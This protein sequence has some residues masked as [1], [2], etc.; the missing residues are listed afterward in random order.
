MQAGYTINLKKSDLILV[1]DLVFIGGRFRIDLAQMFLP[2][3]R[4][5]A[6]IS[7]VWSFCQDALIS[8]VRSFCQAG[9]YNPAHQF[10]RLLGLMV[11]TLL[12]IPY[13]HLHMR[14][15][16]WHLK[17]RWLS[18]FGL[19]HWMFMNANLV[20]D[21]QWWM[22]ESNLLERRPFMH[23]PHT[24]TVTTDASMVG[25]GGHAQGLGLHSALFH[26]LW[27]Q[28]ERLLHINVLEHLA[29]WLM[30]CSLGEAL[31]SQVIWIESNNT[32]TVA[33]IKKDGG[34]HSQTLN[35]KSSLLYE[36]VIPRS[37]QLQTVHRPG[38]DNVLADYL[39]CH[40]A[41][42]TEWRLDGKLVRRLFS[43]CGPATDRP[44]CVGQQYPSPSLVQSGVSS[45]GYRSECV[46]TTSEQGCLCMLFARFLLWP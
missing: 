36:W 25:C 24:V 40:V 15:V 11:A 6:L 35:H 45:G 22:M 8:C 14:P 23:P 2:E 12:V 41:D 13:A 31:L 17:D 16:Q 37:V 3:A 34:V 20:R 26:R 44:V 33:Y 19:N 9:S 7:C 1:Q 39:S 42:P 43:R 21:L 46:V 5:D 18:L 32:T 28:E 38:V 4:K 27:D 30:L 29:V 10:L